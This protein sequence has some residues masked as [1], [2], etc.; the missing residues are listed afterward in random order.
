MKRKY[1]LPLIVA[2]S[3]TV[4][5]MALCDGNRLWGQQPDGA[6]VLAAGG[7]SYIFRLTLNGAPVGDYTEC[8]GLGSS[9]EI[10]ESVRV[11]SNDLVYIDKSPVT[12][13]WHNIT[14]R[15]DGPGDPRVWEWRRALEEGTDLPVALR[16]GMISVLAPGSVEPVASWTFVDGWAASLTFSD[17]GEEL[18]IVHNG[19]YRDGAGAPG[20]PS[21]R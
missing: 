5:L 4:I 15:R 17:A 9:N 18:V 12:L 8:S 1:V 13:E 10:D 20:T 6:A 11:R 7:D 2:C 21:R 19:L 3:L 14:L 16:T